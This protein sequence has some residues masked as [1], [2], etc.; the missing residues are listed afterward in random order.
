MRIGVLRFWI[1]LLVPV[2]SMLSAMVTMGVML[3]LAMLL[4]L[5]KMSRDA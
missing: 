2:L 3:L 4:L 1:L 5:S